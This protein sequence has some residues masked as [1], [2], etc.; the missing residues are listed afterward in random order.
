MAADKASTSGPEDDSS[1]PRAT[2]ERRNL[3]VF[4][5]H[6]LLGMTGFRLLQAPTFLPSY[7]SILTGSS[8][9]VGAWIWSTSS[10]I[11]N[12]ERALCGV[13]GGAL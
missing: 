9:A 5:A 6:G 4:L 1:T 7:I 3:A 2:N 13:V 8:A 12:T 10:F 11:D